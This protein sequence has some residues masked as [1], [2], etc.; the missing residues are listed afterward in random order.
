MAS[1]SARA[2]MRSS[3]ARW[4]PPTAV[5]I[6]AWRMRHCA[7]PSESPSGAAPRGRFARELARARVLAEEVVDLAENDERL[8]P[9]GVVV[10]LLE[11]RDRERQPAA[12]PARARRG[13]TRC[14]RGAAAQ[15]AFRCACLRPARTRAATPRPA[16]A[17]RRSAPCDGGPRRASRRTRRRPSPVTR[18]SRSSRSRSVAAVSRPRRHDPSMKRNISCAATS[19]SPARRRFVTRCFMMRRDPTAGCFASAFAA[20]RKIAGASL[21]S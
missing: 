18:P 14:A 20:S 11:M 1:N 5:A 15:C 17:P 7:R 9:P 10:E 16:R 19:S 4:K 13:P 21:R 8:R 3:R 6:I 2:S 12:A